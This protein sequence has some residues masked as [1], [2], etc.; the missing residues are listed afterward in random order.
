[1][2]HNERSGLNGFSVEFLL[3]ASP[4]SSQENNASLNVFTSVFMFQQQQIGYCRFFCSHCNGLGPFIVLII[5]FGTAALVSMVLVSAQRQSMSFLQYYCQILITT[6]FFV[7]I[8]TCICLTVMPKLSFIV[9]YPNYL[10]R[11]GRG[12]KAGLMNDF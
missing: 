1:M 6:F 4:T 11:F 7:L 12:F 9:N 2:D 8:Y 5:D 3:A 10:Q